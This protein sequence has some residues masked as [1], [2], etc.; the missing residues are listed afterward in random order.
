M[1]CV[2]RYIAFHIDNNFIIFIFHFFIF[3]PIRDIPVA[4][5]LLGDMVQLEV[6]DLHN[7]SLKN[8]PPSLIKLTNLK[9]LNVNENHIQTLPDDIG[10]LT[11]LSTLELSRNEL[12]LVP[13]SL[14]QCTLLTTLCLH[15]NALEVLPDSIGTLPLLTK[16]DISGNR[17]RYLPFSIGFSHSLKELILFGNPLEQPPVEEALKNLTHVMWYMRSMSHIAE[18][19]KPPSMKYHSIGLAE[20]R[21]LLKP[22]VKLFLAG[23]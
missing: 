20:E 18:R 23:E 22:E 14:L 4:V 21:T 15:S 13:V 19:G 16:L 11:S 2:S 1:F 3:F 8:I 7:N 5:D 12:Q 6:L 17:I 10:D 9:T